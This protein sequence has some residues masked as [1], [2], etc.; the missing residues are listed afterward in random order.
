MAEW[1][2][3]KR[4]F[5]K[6]GSYDAYFEATKNVRAHASVLYFAGDLTGTREAYQNEQQTY[7]SS[8][9]RYA[10]DEETLGVVYV[11]DFDRILRNL[12]I[13]VLTLF[14]EKDAPLMPQ[15]AIKKSIF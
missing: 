1:I 9:H 4:I 13:H 3:G 6:G 10:L 14:G 2:R 15:N 11:P 5:M 8:P 7:L 12:D